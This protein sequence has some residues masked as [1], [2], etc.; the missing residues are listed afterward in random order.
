VSANTPDRPQDFSGL[1]SVQAQ[2]G[3]VAR[4]IARIAIIVLAVVAGL[5][6]AYGALLLVLWGLSFRDPAPDQDNCAFGSVSKDEYRR[7]LGE[8]KG[9]KWTVWP[10]LSDGLFWPTDRG[11]LEQP[12][13]QAFESRLGQH[14][15]HSIEQLTFDHGSADAQ[16]A[17]AHA[18]MRSIRAEYVSVGEVLSFHT[19]E[20]QLIPPT[21]EFTYFFPQL[22]FAPLC[23]PCLIFRY[24]TLRVFFHRDRTDVLADVSVLN[25]NLK[26]TPNKEEQRN[27][28]ACPEFPSR[29]TGR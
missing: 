8:A 24:T 26:Y 16:L 27:A 9:Q 19:F 17:A 11:P 12:D 1:H 10:G 28:G 2:Q 22:R 4:R 21:V 20:G 25:S 14:F 6:V 7:L 5:P 3:N 18:I 15:R 29:P 13:G 23:A